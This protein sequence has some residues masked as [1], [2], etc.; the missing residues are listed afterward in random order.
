MAAA[1]HAKQRGKLTRV[2]L[3]VLV[4]KLVA[5]D[6]L[7]TCAVVV[8]EVTTLAHEVGNDAVEARAFETKALFASAERAEVL[9]CLWHP[10]YK[11]KQES[12][13]LNANTQ[14]EDLLKLTSRRPVAQRNGRE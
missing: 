6:G 4:F 12:G 7:A 2:G 1:H 10:A 9:A 13:W 8:G 14:A 11:Q 3:Q 5:V